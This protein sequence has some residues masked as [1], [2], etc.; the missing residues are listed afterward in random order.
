[1]FNI[2]DVVLSI[3][4]LHHAFECTC[5]FLNSM[6]LGCKVVFA[7]SYKSTELVEDMRDNGVSYMC[8]VPLLYEKMYLGFRRKIA[9][10]SVFKRGLFKTLF[11]ISAYGQKR[12]WSWGRGL[13]KSM[14]DKAGMGSL[15]M[16]VSGGAA[17][18]IEISRFFSAIGIAM[19]QGYGL[20][21]T[22]PVLSVNPVE[23]N[24]FD[25]IGPP[26]DGVE[27]RIDNPDQS[28]VGEIVVNG[29]MVMLGY[30]KNDA[31]TAAVLRQGW[32]FTGDVGCVD[33]DGYMYITGRSKNVIVSAA[34][35]NIH[36]EEIEALL[37]ESLYI[38]ESLVLGRKAPNSNVED[39]TAVIVPD[40]DAMME[41]EQR[42]VRDIIQT[43][44]ASVCSRLADFKRIKKYYIRNE[45]LPKTSTRKV[46]R[47][48]EIDDIGNLFEKK[49]V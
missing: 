41:G 25:S 34:G 21:E 45:E 13:F 27:L 16:L 23:L 26:L 1:D 24:K 43:E 29:P 22:S 2:D 32:F 15:R 12:H 40:L 47:C 14:R 48:L 19:L 42:S 9:R 35:K 20:S 37:N 8:G 18:P 44:V 10:S 28:G 33:S 36:P 6:S 4:P 46:K 17:I 5:G 30:Y 38:L 7:R 11:S 3:L 39:V 31:A 49:K